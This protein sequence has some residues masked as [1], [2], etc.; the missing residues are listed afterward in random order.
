MNDA[1]GGELRRFGQRHQITRQLAAAAV[2]GA[3]NR[4]AQGR[5]VAQSFRAG[6][7]TVRVTTQVQRRLVEADQVTILAAL[8]GALNQSIVE[9]LRF[10][11]RRLEQ[12]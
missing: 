11:I 5:F 1:V 6:A 2:V 9:R 4:L 3:A 8:N 7:L 12:P 10:S